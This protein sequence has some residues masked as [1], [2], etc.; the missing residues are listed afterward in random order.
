MNSWLS[1]GIKYAY[2][3]NKMCS[4]QEESRQTLKFD[5][6]NSSESSISEHL[7][8]DCTDPADT[9]NINL[10]MCFWPPDECK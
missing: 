3:V 7:A 4:E 10:W 5:V 8:T 1:W 2:T 6:S 9:D